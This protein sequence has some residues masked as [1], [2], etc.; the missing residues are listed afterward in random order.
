MKTLTKQTVQFTI[1]KTVTETHS[2]EVYSTDAE[3]AIHSAQQA[4]HAETF[5]EVETS[6]QTSWD[7]IDVI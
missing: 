4:D 2:F 5:V 1:T 3:N 6:E 7:L